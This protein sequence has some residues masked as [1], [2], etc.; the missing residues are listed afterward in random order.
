MCAVSWWVPRGVFGRGMNTWMG[1]IMWTL[2]RVWTSDVVDV[3]EYV[4]ISG[5]DL[6]IV[7]WLACRDQLACGLIPSS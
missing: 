7:A 5:R 2:E 4:Q 1:Y 6:C 3:V